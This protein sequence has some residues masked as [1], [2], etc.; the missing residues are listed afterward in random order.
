VDLIWVGAGTPAIDKVA[1][2]LLG[3][4]KAAGIRVGN[5]TKIG[6]AGGLPHGALVFC[7]PESRTQGDELIKALNPFL[8]NLEIRLENNSRLRLHL[9]GT[10]SFERDG[11]VSIE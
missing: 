5:T 2:E 3:L 10:P 9:N 4:F 11:A 8:R 6:M 7:A 1:D